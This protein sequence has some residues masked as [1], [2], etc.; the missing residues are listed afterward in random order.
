MIFKN[1]KAHASKQAGTEIK[2]CVITIPSDWG[3]AARSAIVNAAYIG[4]LSVLSLIN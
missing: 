3:L 2:D 1:I 4:D